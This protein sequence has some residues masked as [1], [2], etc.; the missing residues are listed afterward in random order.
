MEPIGYFQMKDNIVNVVFKKDKENI[1]LLIALDSQ[2]LIIL[3][4]N[5]LP[6]VTT[7][8]LIM[9]LDDFLT[10]RIDLVSHLSLDD[11]MELINASFH[12]NPEF[13]ENVLVIFSNTTCTLIVE[14]SLDDNVEV[15][16]A[17]IN[18]LPPPPR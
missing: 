18:T 16:R 17:V 9:S 6:D 5:N 11:T 14:L 1:T 4:L 2:E 10:R 15:Q 3:N 13:P 8:N 7:E 12:L